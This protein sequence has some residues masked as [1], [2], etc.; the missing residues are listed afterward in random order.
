MPKIDF[1][2]TVIF[3]AGTVW[4]ALWACV[5][6]WANHK[7]STVR[8]RRAR[9]FALE[10]ARGERR[11]QFNSF[12]SGFRSWAE[13][14]DVPERGKDFN[15]RVNVFREAIGRIAS[16]VPESQ[17][18]RFV[19]AVTLLCQL[20]ISDVTKCNVFLNEK[21]EAEVNDIGRNRLT[22]AIDAV[23]KTLD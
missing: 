13:R 3:I 22:D 17:K 10:D 6:W 11:R 7:L 2:P 18:P 9:K 8:D 14:T 21:G 19:I 20:T 4:A 23:T 1:N 12:M 15:S 5:G 16:D